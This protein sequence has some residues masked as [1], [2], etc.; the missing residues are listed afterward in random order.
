M[1]RPRSQRAVA[2]PFHECE[3][4]V[5]APASPVRHGGDPCHHWRHHGTP[6]RL[7]PA[8]GGG[9][10]G[11]ADP[12][13][14]HR[15]ARPAQV[16]RHLPGRAGGG[17]RR[18]HALRRLR[19]RRLQ[20]GAGERRAGP[21]RPEQLRAAPV[22]RLLRH[23]GPDVLRHLQHRRHA[24]SSGDPRQ[25][26]RRNLDRARE[27][28]FSFYAAPEME[29]FY[30]ADADTQRAAAAARPGVVLRPHHRRRRVR[31]P[32]AHDPHAR[33]DGHPG[34]VQP[35][36]G[37]AEPARDRPAL[38]RRPHDGRQRHDVPAGGARGRLR[39]RRARHL[40]AEAAR[41]RAGLG[42][43]HPL[44]A[45]RGRHQRVLRP[46]RRAQPLEGRPRLHRRRAHPR[47]GDRGGHEPVGELL[48]A[49]GGRASRR[50]CT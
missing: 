14:V 15:R 19:H 33:G 25:V 23:L 24:R 46:G 20:P 49:P 22:G 9:A 7:R 3:R 10:R 21:P 17:L 43:A 39:G 18:G 11:P 6:A 45:L 40:H 44:L 13:L 27:R 1:C 50:R 34:G 26:L 12:A 2:R 47:P 31:P 35:P 48:Q 36:R 38:H 41:P 16:L 32:A 30:F 28:G 4:Y 42:D 8:H 5:N 29:F 37:R